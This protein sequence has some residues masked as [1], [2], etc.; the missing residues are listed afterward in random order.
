QQRSV[1][2]S[3][4]DFLLIVKLSNLLPVPA[5]MDDR[6]EC[7]HRLP[8]RQFFVPSPIVPRKFSRM[9]CLTQFLFGE[10]PD[11]LAV[12]GNVNR[13]FQ[14]LVNSTTRSP[15]ADQRHFREVHDVSSQEGI[16]QRT[17]LPAKKQRIFSKY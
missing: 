17:L 10:R 2:E 12:F 8:F 16:N 9:D 11:Y 6:N 4:D 7:V 3:T 15:T 1:A 14:T 13:V 5:D